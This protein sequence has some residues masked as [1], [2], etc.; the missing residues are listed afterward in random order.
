VLSLSK[1]IPDQKKV[2]MSKHLTLEQRHYIGLEKD[3]STK[4][5]IAKKLGVAVSTISR[6]IKRNTGG[7]NYRYK[8][9]DELAKARYKNKPKGYT[10]S[11][12]L[13]DCVVNY[14]QNDWSPE[15]ISGYL[16]TKESV[17]IHHETIY[18]YLVKDK[19]NNGNLYLHLRR[20]GKKQ[21]KQYGSGKKGAGIPNRIDISARSEEINQRGRVGDWEADTIIGKNHQGCIVT[22]DERKTKLRMAFPL[23][24]KHCIPVSNAIIHLLTPF[25]QFVHSITF[26][27][28]KEFCAHEKIDK[29]LSC[30]S[31]FATPYHSWERGQNENANGLLRQYFP[32]GM[33]L[34]DI[35]VKEVMI[36][37]DKLNSRPRKCL[38]Y[39]TPYETFLEATGID[40][41][42][43]VILRL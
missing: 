2:F 16:R 11:G 1:F 13:L 27:N 28:G 32:K 12:N 37:V 14:I 36:A 39:R 7:R 18:R 21:R 43:F 24:S 29:Q 34:I 15:Q 17:S 23:N 5:S 10:L 20:Q 26:D 40:A 19:A 38:G 35:A 8:Q 6:E 3:T 22:L 30:Q 9:A 4:S 42:A 25:K 31:Y 41:R 33:K